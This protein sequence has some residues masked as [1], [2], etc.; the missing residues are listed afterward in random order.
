MM[1]CERCHVMMKNGTSYE[2][3]K[4]RNN[5]T[6]FMECPKCHNRRYNNSMNFQD[7]FTKSK[8]ING[9]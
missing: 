8:M 7:L 1:I 9:V 3:R 2:N 4:G 5:K 6:R